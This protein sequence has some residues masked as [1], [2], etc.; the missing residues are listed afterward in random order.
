M[1]PRTV[2]PPTLGS[3]PSSNDAVQSLVSE[4]QPEAVSSSFACL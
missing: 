2:R 3:Q 4:G 1:W